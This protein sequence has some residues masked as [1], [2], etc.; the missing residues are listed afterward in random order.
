M[1]RSDVS[2]IKKREKWIYYRTKGNLS[3]GLDVDVGWG[4]HFQRCRD[5]RG[6]HKSVNCEWGT[7]N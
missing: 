2:K 7:C 3:L 5:I 6:I 4:L 1:K